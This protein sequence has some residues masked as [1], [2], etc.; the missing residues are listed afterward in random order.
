MFP[1]DESYEILPYPAGKWNAVERVLGIIILLVID[2]PTLALLCATHSTVLNVLVDP[3]N[4]VL[5]G[6]V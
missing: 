2:H 4:G 3:C 6:N 5:T 1:F